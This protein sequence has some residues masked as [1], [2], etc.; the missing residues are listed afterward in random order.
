MHHVL[1]RESDRGR[2]RQAEQEREREEEDRGRERETGEGGREGGRGRG[3]DRWKGRLI[4]NWLLKP[5]Q[6]WR[7]YQGDSNVINKNKK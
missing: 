3:G 1:E 4:D 2:E 7:S 5:S 6:P